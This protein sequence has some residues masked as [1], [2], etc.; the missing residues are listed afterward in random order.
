MN[1]FVRFVNHF[2]RSSENSFADSIVEARAWRDESGD[3]IGDNG[4]SSRALY[5]PVGPVNIAA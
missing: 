2:L 4:V 3:R 5:D 1:D